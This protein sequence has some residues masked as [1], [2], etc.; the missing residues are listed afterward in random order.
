VSFLQSIKDQVVTGSTLLHSF[1][2]IEFQV[3]D[4]E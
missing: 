2:I 3:L 4:N 1:C